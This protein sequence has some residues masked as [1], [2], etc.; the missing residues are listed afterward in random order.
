MLRMVGYMLTLTTYGTW[1][2]G[3]EKGFV[4]DGVVRGENVALKADCEK[5]LQSRPMRLNRRKKAIVREALIAASEKFGQ[6]IFGIAVQSN[7]VHM[8]C[9]YVEASIGV[10]VARYKS[11]G[12]AALGL[13]GVTGKVWTKG[14]DVRYCY[15]Q[16]NLKAKIRYVE[17][18]G[19]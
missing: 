10:M 12:R 16:A 8:V 5:K 3:N 14:Y 6:R 18:H 2:Q 7:H 9:E 19:D 15:D 4:K 17:G 13:E 1:L 11:A